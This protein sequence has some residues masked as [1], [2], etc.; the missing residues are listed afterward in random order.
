MM[1]RPLW[2]VG[3]MSLLVGIASAQDHA[4]VKTKPFNP[5]VKEA[6]E[7]AKANLPRAIAILE[8]ALQNKPDDR[9]ALYLIGAMAFVTGDRSDEKSER[10][11]MFRRSTEAF[12]RLQDS[13]KDLTSYEKAFLARSRIGE[14]CVLASEGNADKA[15]AVIERLLA[16]GFDDLDSITDAKDLEPVRKLPGFKRVLERS[17]RSGVLDEMATFKPFPFD[18]ELKDLDGRVVKL[19]DSKGKVTIVDIWGTWCPPCR[20]EVP[21]FVELYNEYKD[22]G[23]EIVGINCNESGSPEDVKKKIKRFASEMKLPYR[24]LLNDDK[25]EA[26]IPNFVGYPT[27]LFL[28]R[29]SKVRVVVVG[30]TPKVK[31]EVIIK[32]LLEEGPKPETVTAVP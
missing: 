20:K 12:A 4:E 1:S 21:H 22:E 13:H 26:K 15:L 8:K 29:S 16:S 31:L 28:D 3:L 9:E 24:C 32:T 14:A 25:T 10:I 27:T 17:A 6:L 30:Y 11:A 18:F 23:L 2:I 19:A 5:K 7:A